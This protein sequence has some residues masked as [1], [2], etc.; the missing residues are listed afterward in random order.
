VARIVRPSWAKIYAVATWTLI[1]LFTFFAIAHV[2]LTV[3]FFIGVWDTGVGYVLDYEWPAWLIT[4]IDAVAAL[5]LWS[6]YR[7]GSN[8]PWLGLTLTIVAATLMLA[9]A[10]WMVPVPV[11]VVLTITGSIGRIVMSRRPLEVHE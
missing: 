8:R 1:G 9:R 6:G 3:L 7:R 4:L 2:V 10:S 11:A 5:S